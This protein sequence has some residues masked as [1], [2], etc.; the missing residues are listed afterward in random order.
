MADL[1]AHGV[2]E[3]SSFIPERK[4]AHKFNAV[5]QF[6][7]LVLG[8]LKSYLVP[9]GAFRLVESSIPTACN[10]VLKEGCT[11][12]K[13]VMQLPR[14]LS[15]QLA[16]LFRIPRNLGDDKHNTLWYLVPNVQPFQYLLKFRVVQQ[17]IL[18]NDDDNLDFVRVLVKQLL[19]ENA[20][21]LVSDASVL[22]ISG[23]VE[24]NLIT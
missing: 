23:D 10:D 1:D 24:Q 15:E 3:R 8:S 7:D 13:I 21:Q 6:P 2:A 9:F 4:V 18:I 14:L 19:C 11:V 22:F 5:E 12:D 17:V 16:E 20:Y